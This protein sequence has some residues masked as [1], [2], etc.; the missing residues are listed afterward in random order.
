MALPESGQA[1][2]FKI[3]ITAS[4]ISKAVRVLCESGVLAQP[5]FGVAALAER[6]LRTAL[7][8]PPA[9]GKDSKDYWTPS[10]TALRLDKRL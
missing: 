9:Y 2:A 7:A 5:E 3:E 8:L 6:L 10:R 4:M 1:G